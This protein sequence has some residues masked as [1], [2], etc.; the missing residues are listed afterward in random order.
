MVRLEYNR[1]GLPRF[2]LWSIYRII[3][4]DIVLAWYSGLHALICILIAKFFR[5]KSIVI[6]GGGEVA[7]LRHIRYGSASS[8]VPSLVAKIPLMLADRVIAV[9]SSLVVKAAKELRVS[10][11]NMLVIPL[12]F[13]YEATTDNT[14]KENLVLT[15]A[16]AN[17][18]PRALVKGLDIFSKVAWLIPDC[19]FVIIGVSPEIARALKSVGPANLEVYGPMP[20][21]QVTEYFRKAKVYCQFSLFEGFGSALAEAMLYKCVPVGSPNGAI[22]SIIGDSG[23]IVPLDNDAQIATSVRKALN[24]D[25]GERARNRIIKLFPLERRKRDL[26]RIIDELSS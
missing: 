21:S 24:A 8:I 16:L 19:R 10:T 6:L 1:R 25:L 2:L 12:G 11:K 14:E 15:V 5:K 23:F 9:H 20:W 13:D 22:P 17:S 18:W 4:A 26:L 7:A 3:C